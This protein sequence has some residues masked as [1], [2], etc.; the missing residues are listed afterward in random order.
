MKSKLLLPFSALCFFL[1]GFSAHGQSFPR[2]GFAG[3]IITNV[4]G[5]TQLGGG[6]GSFTPTA[7]YFGYWDADDLTGANNDAKLTWTD[8][9]T[10]AWQ[11]SGS[12]VLKTSAVNGHNAAW[13]GATTNGMQVAAPASAGT[14]FCAFIVAKLDALPDTSNPIFFSTTNANVYFQ[15]FDPSSQHALRWNSGSS[16]ITPTG[17]IFPIGT[18]WCVYTVQ[19]T[20][21]NV[22]TIYTNGVLLATEDGGNLNIE[23]L[24]LGYLSAGNNVFH[25]QIACFLP[26]TNSLTTQQIQDNVSGLGSKYGITIPF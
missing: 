4:V 16:I 15:A 23:G 1:A 10:N 8:K 18:N 6:G 11:L 19:R 2:V 5:A 9:S 25:G 26:Y 14:L 3:L 22:S 7:G 12:T 17:S 21:Y 24:R 20:A 13:F